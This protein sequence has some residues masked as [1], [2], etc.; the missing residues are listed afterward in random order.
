M[1]IAILVNAFPLP[2]ETYVLSHI[3]G[4]LDRGCEVTIFADPPT[5]A[6]PVHPDV[7]AY[8]LMGRAVFAPVIP[9]S[10]GRRL[11]KGIGL[12]LR[13]GCRAPLVLLRTLNVFKH[14]RLA[15]SLRLLYDAVSCLDQEGYDIIHCHFGPNGIRGLALR[16]AGALTGKLVTTFH[17]YDVSGYVQ[18]KGPHCY[19]RLFREGDLFIAIS[20]TMR[21]QLMA[22][23][24]DEERIVVQRIGVDLS[25]F[26]PSLSGHHRNGPTR[27]LTIGRLVPKKGV[28]DGVR[29]VTTLL[30]AGYGL[31]YDVIGDG[32]LRPELER[33]IEEWG[34]GDCVRLHGARGESEVL[35]A[36]ERSDILLT[37][38]LTGPDGDQ[39]G[40]PV[41]LLEGMAM[42]LPTVSTVHSGIPELVEDDVSGFLVQEGDVGAIS[43]KLAHLIDRPQLRA[44]MGRAGQRAVA[45]RFDAGQL[46][47]ELIQVYHD[48]LQDPASS[49]VGCEERVRG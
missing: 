34:V 16:E 7:E 23:G 33:L 13:H 49:P 30:Q 9:P 41:V 27:V 6:W 42:G 8:G 26:S 12:A 44:R 18:E 40:A 37:P 48:L 11:V 47:S 43:E 1:R 38:S 5:V 14:G 24:C 28:E 45:A 46:N 15:A 29:A 21:R 39:E 3:T 36:L 20:E 2:S 10:Y 17:G 22:L 31:R 19:D 32:P 25:R 4:L 35:N